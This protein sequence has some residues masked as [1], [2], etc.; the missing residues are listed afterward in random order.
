M[1]TT[2]FPAGPDDLA[3]RFVW[4]MG[5]AFGRRGLVVEVIAPRRKTNAETETNAKTA[6]ETEIETAT[7][8][9]TGIEQKIS[10]T[11]ALSVQPVRHFWP[12]R[13]PSMFDGLGAVEALTRRPWLWAEAVAYTAALVRTVRARAPHWDCG[14]AHWMLPA[15]VVCARCAPRCPRVVVAH[16]ADVHLLQRLIIDRRLGG[17]WMKNLLC[18]GVRVAF[19]CRAQ[20]QR[21]SDMLD[22]RWA[23]RLERVSAVAPM[24]IDVAAVQGGRRAATRRKLAIEGLGAL[25]L[26]RLVE[27]KRP[28][29]LVALARRTRKVTFV[30]AG[31][32]PL[33][34]RLKQTVEQ[35]GLSARFRFVGPVSGE[36][37]RDLL[38]AGDLLVFPSQTLADGR[39]EGAP[40][41][42]QEGLAAGLPVVASNVGGVAELIEAERTG[43]L[44]DGEDLGAMA[45]QIQRLQQ[46][47]ALLRQAQVQAARAGGRRDWAQVIEGYLTLLAAAAREIG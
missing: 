17:V 38:A 23:D 42:I 43:W 9:A 13:L 33:E 26:G 11:E 22:G 44:F 8:T 19:S 7:A 21:L 14:V 46:N 20:K 16:S 3:G 12:S 5:R 41:V 29:A 28:L 2:S 34:P 30:V 24:G 32:G 45:K 1:V 37:K 35:A 36:K 10:D 27:I 15:G 39:T 4:Q 31:A 47:S 18:P 6:T 25:F 40:V